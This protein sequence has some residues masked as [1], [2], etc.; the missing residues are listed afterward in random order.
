M[1]IIDTDTL[2]SALVITVIIAVA[3][4]VK[5]GRWV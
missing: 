1:N 5:T 2:I 3:Y 4:R